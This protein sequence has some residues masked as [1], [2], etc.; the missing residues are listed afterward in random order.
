MLSRDEILDDLTG[1]GALL[2]GHF[3]LTSGLHSA[4]YI[5]C[6]ALLKQPNLAGKL[7]QELAGKV[8]QYRPEV[9][10][11]PAMG[12]IIVAYEVARALKLSG[13]F[14]ERKAGRMQLRRN[15]QIAPGERVVVVEDVVTTGRS[16]QE[17]IA[18]I[19][20]QRG[21]LVAVAALIDRSGGKTDFGVPFASLLTLDIEVYS[22]EDC[23]LCRT[24]S[25]V[26]KPGSRD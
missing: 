17:V 7:C 16:V 13:I 2:N 24:G 23:P 18:L 14:A 1:A 19:K 5:Q 22:T 8:R 4:Q 11:G 12:G 6:A 25:P 20:Q 21:E 10:I 15:F 9:I 26:V 3:L